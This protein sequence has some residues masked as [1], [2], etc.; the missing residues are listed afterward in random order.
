MTETND[1]LIKKLVARKSAKIALRILKVIA[2]GY[3][4][5]ISGWIGM[6]FLSPKIVMWGQ[7]LFHFF[8]SSVGWLIFYLQYHFSIKPN[9]SLSI[10]VY[11]EYFLLI[12]DDNKTKY[13]FKDIRKL[14]FKAIKVF[15]YGRLI[16]ETKTGN[17]IRLSS[18]VE[19]LDLLVDKIIE[20]NPTILNQRD[21]IRTRDRIIFLDHS[22]ARVHYL[23]DQKVYYKYGIITFIALPILFTLILYFKQRNFIHS[24][25]SGQYFGPLFSYLFI[26]PF[27]Y[28]NFSQILLNYYFHGKLRLQILRNKNKARDL[29]QEYFT[30]KVLYLSSAALIISIFS[31]LV[32]TDNNTIITYSLKRSFPQLT[33]QYGNR[34]WVDQKYFQLNGKYALQQDDVVM[35][36]SKGR[37]L[38]GKV[39]VHNNITD[40]FRTPAALNL[41]SNQIT[42]DT[43]DGNI[44]IVQENDIIG[45]IISKTTI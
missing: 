7:N 19:R 12:D 35:F 23:Y 44:S 42:I 8:V 16:L 6:F 10:E 4:A 38:I 27:I 21:L 31:F 45:K 18:T 37:K 29:F 40:S 2:I 17:I 26:I 3:I 32:I 30:F 25:G 28:F 39:K 34:I 20:Y 36:T 1:F 15:L 33:Y 22:I 14:K 13:Y 11:P 5:S 41:N 43:L 24:T 9:L